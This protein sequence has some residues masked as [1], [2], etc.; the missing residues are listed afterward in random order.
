M[1]VGS[2]VFLANRAQLSAIDN[3]LFSRLAGSLPDVGLTA[4]IVNTVTNARKNISAH[5]DISNAMFMGQCSVT[6]TQ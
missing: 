2:Q 5:Y 3:S 6:T 4:R 1:L